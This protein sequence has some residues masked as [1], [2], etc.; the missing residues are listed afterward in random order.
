MNNNTIDNRNENEGFLAVHISTKKLFA[1]D[2][3]IVEAVLIA[4]QL[5]LCAIAF[6]GYCNLNNRDAIMS[7][8]S[9]IIQMTLL[10]SMGMILVTG[11]YIYFASKRKK[12]IGKLV[13]KVS[14]FAILFVFVSNVIFI[15]FARTLY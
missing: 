13:V 7:L 9:L 5:G 15:F 11:G 4:L 10:G 14:F 12:S 2:R 8:L 3:F 6:M 1:T